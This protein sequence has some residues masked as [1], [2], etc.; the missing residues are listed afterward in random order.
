[1]NKLVV[2]AFLNNNNNERQNAKPT[3][4]SYR[5]KLDNVI[6]SRSV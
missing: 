4:N 5:L 6:S 1:L 3:D 2:D